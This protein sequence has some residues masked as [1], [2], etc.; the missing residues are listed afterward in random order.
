[1]KQWTSQASL[2]DHVCRHLKNMP[3][4]AECPHPLCSSILDEVSGAWQHLDEH[5]GLAPNRRSP[6]KRSS[7]CSE[8]GSASDK[9]RPKKLACLA[10]PGSD[11]PEVKELQWEAV[12][13]LPQAQEQFGSTAEPS[14]DRFYSSSSRIIDSG[15]QSPIQFQLPF[16]EQ[17]RELPWM[18]D[19]RSDALVD[20][21][22]SVESSDSLPSLS[23]LLASSSSSQTTDLSAESYYKSGI[24]NE[25][26]QDA[27]HDHKHERRRKLNAW[28]PELEAIPENS[29]EADLY[30][31]ALESVDEF[32]KRSKSGPTCSKCRVVMSKQSLVDREDK[33]GKCYDIEVDSMKKE[34][35]RR[36]YPT[37]SW[38]TLPE[39]LR[40]HTPLLLDVLNGR[41]ET[42]FQQRY[43]D[44]MQ[45]LKD[46]GTAMTRSGYY[47]PRGESLM[48]VLQLTI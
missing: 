10:S 15:S 46:Y 37:I 47:G 30:K 22:D 31:F 38:N 48:S 41:F 2:L 45:D 42:P 17:S 44:H 35:D 24:T 4:P 29:S 7:E 36:S 6:P 5:H 40:S 14:T 12:M 9:A 25:G 32:A 43:E 28:S 26:P 13:T 34:W 1:M 39:R 3:L 16:L 21:C 23:S 33:C 11:P 18:V 20:D 8:V 27:W 19:G